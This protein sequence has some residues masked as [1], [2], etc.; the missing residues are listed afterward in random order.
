MIE[1]QKE[2]RPLLGAP[3][4]Q[5]RLKVFQPEHH[6][7]GLPGLWIG[8]LHLHGAARE[9]IPE[10][11]HD[12]HQPARRQIRLQARRPVGVERDALDRG[13][14]MGRHVEVGVERFDP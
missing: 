7:L 13:E 10:L 14:H 11:A 6:G 1:G 4:N 5:R 3:G 9:A 12:G 8:H 2:G